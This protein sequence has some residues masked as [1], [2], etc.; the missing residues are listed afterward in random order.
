[1]R[2][3]EA[4][5]LSFSLGVDPYVFEGFTEPITEPIREINRCAENTK[6]MLNFV[7][8][9]VAFFM[10][11]PHNRERKKSSSLSE[12]LYYNKQAYE[13]Y[14]DLISVLD[15]N[16]ALLKK[17]EETLIQALMMCVCNEK[18]ASQS[19]ELKE[20]IAQLSDIKDKMCC[21]SDIINERDKFDVHLIN[22]ETREIERCTDVLHDCIENWIEK[23]SI[24]VEANI[25]FSA[26]WYE[27]FGES[28]GCQSSIG[29]RSGGGLHFPL[30]HSDAMRASAP[31]ALDVESSDWQSCG[32]FW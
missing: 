22:A 21:V 29:L 28:W 15:E 13:V 5:F 24:I 4:V 25:K 26:R 11:C 6:L 1:M 30:T 32:R 12:A 9:G 20:S 10:R 18:K 8:G 23:A 3:V 27:R 2:S 7:V 31:F 17:S 19:M 16:L 14:T